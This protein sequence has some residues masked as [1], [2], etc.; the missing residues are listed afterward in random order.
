MLTLFAFR[1]AIFHVCT[2]MQRILYISELL[3]MYKQFYFLQ[4]SQ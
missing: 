2:S 4:R 1:V 3:V